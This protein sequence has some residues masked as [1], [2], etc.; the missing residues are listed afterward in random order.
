MLALFLTADAGKVIGMRV[1][2]GFPVTAAPNP[3]NI[4][5]EYEESVN[6]FA[7]SVGL[8][9][10]PEKTVN[11]HQHLRTHANKRALF[12]AGLYR[13]SDD[14]VYTVMIMQAHTRD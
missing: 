3:S 8:F 5:S 2:I 13:F 10:I 4:S 11:R 14:D 12:K 7:D 1:S 6:V 9:I